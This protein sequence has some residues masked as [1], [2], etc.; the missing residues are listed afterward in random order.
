MV[1]AGRQAR[2]SCGAKAERDLAFVNWRRRGP[3]AGSTAGGAGDPGSH[4]QLQTFFASTRIR[5]SARIPPFSGSRIAERF[6]CV[7]PSRLAP[8]AMVEPQSDRQEKSTMPARLKVSHILES[9][10]IALSS[11]VAAEARHREQVRVVLAEA[12]LLRTHLTQ[13]PRDELR[14]SIELMLRRVDQAGESH[15]RQNWTIARLQDLLKRAGRYRN[16]PDKELDVAPNLFEILSPFVERDEA[17]DCRIAEEHL[18]R[19]ARSRTIT[20]EKIVRHLAALCTMPT[21]GF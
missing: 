21:R 7:P 11:G 1:P 4:R 17:S 10:R 14:A 13:A 15:R 6:G 2:S 8:R 9:G 12:R 20:R 19:A 3:T 16:E 18:R 5:S